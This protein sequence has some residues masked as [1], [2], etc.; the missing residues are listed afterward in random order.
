MGCSGF[1]GSS[2]YEDYSYLGEMVKS[3][4][5]EGSYGCQNVFEIHAV[6]VEGVC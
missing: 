6:L 5:T 4:L 3:Q 1:R 2:A